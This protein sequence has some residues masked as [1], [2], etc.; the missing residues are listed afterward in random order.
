[1]ILQTWGDVIVASL[2]EVW[3]SVAGF[4]PLLIGALIVFIVGW[5]V[6]VSLGKVIEQLV[7]T[8]KVDSVLEKLEFHKVLDRAGLKLDSGA[9]IG[10]LIRWFLIIVF[11]LAALNILNLNEVSAFLRDVLRYIPQVVVAALILVIA[12]LVAE[13]VE[14]TARASVE[15]AGVKGALVGVVARWAIWIFAI[16]A[17]LYQLGIAT[18]LLQT[19]VTGL[20]AMLAIAGGLAFGLGGKDLA[21]DFL[22]RVR[23]EIADRS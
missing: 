11:L 14:R 22:S 4:L 19:L 13:T 17:A 5:I 9:F 20:V 2:Q 7:K 23:R 8:L 21:G 10:G 18:V 15:A 12:A 3:A 1:M 6:A 16:I